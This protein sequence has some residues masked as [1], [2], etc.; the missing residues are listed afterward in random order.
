VSDRGG[1]YGIAVA[2]EL[3]GVGEQALRLYERK[4]LV[5]P[6]RTAGGTRRYSDRDLEVLR[7]VVELL[8]EGVNLTGARRVLELE[9]ANE[10][11][12]VRIDELTRTRAAVTD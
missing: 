7:R 12:Q 4:G 5:A 11:L 8:A 2:A 3:V 10:T 1:L 9:A 6:A